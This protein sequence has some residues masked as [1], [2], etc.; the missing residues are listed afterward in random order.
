M[1]NAVLIHIKTIRI[2]LSAALCGCIFLSACENDEKVVKE[3]FDKKI[4]VDEA[5]DIESYLSQGGKMKGKLTAPVMFRY[6][7]TLPR[8]EFPNTLHV[9]FFDDSLTIESQLDARFARYFES[10]NKVFLKDSVT[11]FNIQGDTLHC[12]EL[13]WDQGLQKFHT[14][15]PVRIHRKDMI[16]IGVGL[17]APQNFKTF[18]MYKI[19]NSIIRMSSSDFPG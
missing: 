10:Q 11:V 1:N 13:W 14:D 6:Q 3:F 15:K 4:G 2:I 16:M 17:S 12:Q 5:R 19:T 9:D 8:I 18:E 7:D